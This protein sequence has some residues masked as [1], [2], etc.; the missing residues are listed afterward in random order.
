[1]LTLYPVSYKPKDA[2]PFPIQKTYMI[3]LIFPPIY[4]D[5]PDKE[6]IVFDHIFNQKCSLLLD[7]VDKSVSISKD[8]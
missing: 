5:V 4:Q 8:T 2:I 3:D 7:K 1:M 6:A